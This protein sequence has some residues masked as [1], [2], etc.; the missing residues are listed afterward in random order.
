MASCYDL[1]QVSQVAVSW[2]V[3]EVGDLAEDRSQELVLDSM[4][5]HLVMKIFLVL[6]S[7]VPSCPGESFCLV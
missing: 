3:L 5:C 4:I 2:D 7:E 6:D 1:A